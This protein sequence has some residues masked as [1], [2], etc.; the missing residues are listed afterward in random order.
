MSWIVI[1]IPASFNTFTLVGLTNV[2]KTERECWQTLIREQFPV[3]TALPM[4]SLSSLFVTLTLRIS[5]REMELEIAGLKF[6]GGAA[7]IAF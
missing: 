2:Y 3:L 4:A 7:P 6:K 5:I 1:V